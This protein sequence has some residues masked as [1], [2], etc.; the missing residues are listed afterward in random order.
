MGGKGANLNTL[1]K[2]GL[3]VPKAFVISSRAY[4]SHIERPAIR[5]KIEA[6]LAGEKN[7]PGLLADLRQSMVSAPLDPGLAREISAALSG[8]GPGRFAVRSSATCEDS[9]AHSFAG[10][11]DTVLGVCSSEDCLSAVKQCW[12]S[13]WS[14]R[15]IEYRLRNGID[16]RS[17]G[18]A[19]VVQ[20]LVL[21][22]V[23]G[24]MFTSDPVSGSRDK[25]VIESVFGLGEAL[26]SGRVQPDRM[27]V[28][29]QSMEVIERQVSEKKFAIVPG[30]SSGTAEQDLDASRR[31]MPSLDDE[32]AR[33]I[34]ELGARIEALFKSPQD[35]E[36]AIA[37]GKVFILQSRPITGPKVQDTPGD[38]V[39]WS[40]TNAGEILPGVITPMT[41]SVIK[42]YVFALFSPLSSRMALDMDRLEVMGLVAGRI[43]FNMNVATAML[44]SFPG[45]S[46]RNLA[47][48]FGGEQEQLTK[49]LAGI[50]VADLPKT[51]VKPLRVLLR[52]PGLLLWLAR[53]RSMEVE[54]WEETLRRRTREFL[55]TDYKRMTALEILERTD[56]ISREVSGLAED[57]LAFAVVGLI[58]FRWLESICRRWLHDSDGSIYNRLLTGMGG[59]D[60][61]Q[62]GLDLWR[63]A[64][65][66][67][68]PEIF[69]AVD[70]AQDF[71]R[72][73]ET[74]SGN[75]EGSAFLTKWDAF[76]FW[77]GHH[78]RAEA[79]VSAARW[80]EQD[81][82]VL[83]MV[84]TF[85]R[86]RSSRSLLELHREKAGERE[87]LE[88]EIRGRLRDPFRRGIFQWFLTRAQKGMRVR[89]NAKNGAVR[90]L[91]IVRRALLELGARFAGRGLIDAR[92][93]V[94]FL[95]FEELSPAIGNRLDFDLRQEVKSRRAEYDENLK[96]EPPSLVIGRFD[97]L[98]QQAPASA[99]A[100]PVMKGIA[101][102][103]GVAM[104]KA[105][106]ILMA[107]TQDRVEPGEILVAPFT[108]PGWT[109]YFLPAAGIVVE[110][111]GALS[112]GSVV[113]R[114]YGIPAVVN[115]KGATRLIRT[116]QTIRV[117]GN[118]GEV[119]ILNPEPA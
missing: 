40:N 28:D 86:D 53:H 59:V 64:E 104:G 31:A 50:K 29:K 51:E 55:L 79:D 3:P 118:K 41:F 16:P 22:E 105:R 7:R 23:S 57:G 106:V 30:K 111:G 56:Q 36:W 113:A 83:E 90:N 73:R 58:C 74:L 33:R 85:A 92:D 39:I 62:A 81:D 43:Y 80:R 10:Q 65:A 98:S 24:V 77:H 49:A 35:I 69:E 12:A 46:K 19:V 112:H 47:D 116:G 61:A 88:A 21:A 102:S 78:C 75:P 71:Q 99:N 115:V 70:R 108:D 67:R 89:E 25:I 110:L 5:E 52:L 4:L 13:A 72:A 97:P 103:A 109:P 119:V 2:H 17:G 44:R 114:E 68:A 18:M 87:K 20:E 95:T 48:F 15:A 1:I 26:V 76:M 96:V 100:G 9:S 101:V 32:Q 45:T 38:R 66:A 37:N 8:L 117:D 84:R 42:K 27:A 91:A 34:A 60:S 82:F 107:N 14:E 54:A 11:H 94:F 63:L 93:D 6:A